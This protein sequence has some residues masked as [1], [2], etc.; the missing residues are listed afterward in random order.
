MQ[1]IEEFLNDMRANELSD[2]TIKNVKRSLELLDEFKPLEECT[3]E[4]I[5]AFI[6][7]LNGKYKTSSL[8][9]RKINIKQFFKA[10]GRADLVDHIKIKKVFKDIDTTKL[11]TV[12]DVNDLIEATA[13][14]KYRAI[15]AVMWESGARINEVLAIKRNDIFET[16]HGFE[17]KIY[18]SKTANRTGNGY[19]K[20]LLIESAGHI[21]NYQLES[22]SSDPRLFPVGY[23]STI[24]ALRK[25]GTAIGMDGIYPHLI[26]HSKATSLV[27][28]NVQES[29]I[30]RQ[31]GWTPDSPMIKRYIHLN[32]DDLIQNQLERAGIKKEDV[33]QSTGLI[34][35]AESKLNVLEEANKTLSTEMEDIKKEMERQEKIKKNLQEMNSNRQDNF[36]KQA[37]ELGELRAAQK[38]TD[39][40]MNNIELLIEKRAFEILKGGLD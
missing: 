36:E 38:K 31:L 23:D 37:K 28:E 20:I 33:V 35:P 24:R 5:T 10:Q 16:D 3:R 25:A 15:W 4:D 39:E 12:D 40:K 2:Q 34:K 8:Q 7:S 17:V 32:D 26:R 22:T 11:L 30:R 9:V 21:R 1:S 18:S 13:S 14:L 27:K 29:I 19:R 6:V